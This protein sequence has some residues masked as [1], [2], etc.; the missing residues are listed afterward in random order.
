[1]CLLYI[2][3]MYVY[4]YL[5]VNNMYT[6]AYILYMYTHKHTHTHTHTHTQLRLLLC[7]FCV[8]CVSM[9]IIYTI[10]IFIETRISYLFET[11]L[12]RR[13]H[14]SQLQMLGRCLRRS[15]RKKHGG[16]WTAQWNQTPA[17][18]PPPHTQTSSPM[19][20]PCTRSRGRTA[21]TSHKRLMNRLQREWE[22]C[23]HKTWLSRLQR[24]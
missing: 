2:H 17:R 24:E 21:S 12:M 3:V 5:H 9:N 18:V 20:P 22:P 1:M 23:S 11:R 16:V 13:R 19:S 6:N 15:S 10:I 7:L 4:M 14:S 8:R